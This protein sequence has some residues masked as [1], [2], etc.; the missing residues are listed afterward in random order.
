M[1][2]LGI[3]AFHGDAA[4]ALVQEGGPVGAI[5]EEH[6][7]RRKHRAGFPSRGIWVLTRPSA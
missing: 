6:L 1:N 4:V 2:I 7:N 3:N 5:E